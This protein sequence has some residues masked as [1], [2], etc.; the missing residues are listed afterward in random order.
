MVSKV[1]GIKVLISRQ[2]KV[3]VCLRPREDF[4]VFQTLSAEEVDRFRVVSRC[5]QHRNDIDRH[6]FVEQD[7]HQAGRNARR[8]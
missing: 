7:A 1:S 4:A 2:E 5:A 3:K 8:V 6:V